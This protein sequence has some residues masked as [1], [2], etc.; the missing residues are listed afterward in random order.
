MNE[1]PVEIRR[2]LAQQGYYHRRGAHSF[3]SFEALCA[4]LGEIRFRTDIHI[5]PDKE[6]EQRRTRTFGPHR[7]GV[8]TDGELAFHTDNP[9]WSILGW[10]CVEQDEKAGE[11]L[12]LDLGD[13]ARAFSA[14]ELEELC[15]LRIYLPVRDA[16]WNE[17]AELAPV[18]KPAGSS[19]DV[20]WVPWLVAGGF[21]ETHGAVLRR[22]REWLRQKEASEL[23]SLRL[24]PG[25]ALFIHNNRMLHGRRPLTP[26]SRR[27]L[28]RLAVAAADIRAR[29]A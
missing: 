3:E 14:R 24:Q 4:A 2:A 29:H 28:V 7:P 22:F 13:A 9:N 21:E 23:I 11:S 10:H 15:A 17:T 18:L 16:S 27:Q 5:S 12:L 19:F 26:G 6:A 8:Y 1:D 25:E 20:Y